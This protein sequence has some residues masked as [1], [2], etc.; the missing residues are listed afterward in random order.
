[1]IGSKTNAALYTVIKNNTDKRILLTSYGNMKNGNIAP[2]GYIVAPGYLLEGVP[3]RRLANVYN[4][5]RNGSISIFLVVRTAD[6][7]KTM[8]LGDTSTVRF[9]DA[10]ADA[11]FLDPGSEQHKQTRTSTRTQSEV[12]HRLQRSDD[13][14]T[15]IAAGKADRIAAAIGAKV[16]DDQPTQHA[17]LNTDLTATHGA[18]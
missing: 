8:Q 2:G 4:T 12:G 6:G 7:Y 16:A 10:D 14:F 18:A 5:M 17:A 11:M 13:G 9:T 15:V 1:M 3:D